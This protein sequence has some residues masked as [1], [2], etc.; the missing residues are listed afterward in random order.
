MDVQFPRNDKYRKGNGGN[1]H[2]N[3]RQRY[4]SHFSKELNDRISEDYPNNQRRYEE[5]Y[6]PQ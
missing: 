4:R 2:N 6:R 1:N 3:G 5:E